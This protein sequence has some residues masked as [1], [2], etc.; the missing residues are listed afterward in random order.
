MLQKLK[1]ILY[2]FV[3]GTDWPLGD[4]GSTEVFGNLATYCIL[5]LKVVFHILWAK[6]RQIRIF[7]HCKNEEK[8]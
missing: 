5:L 8:F 1:W 7:V 6:L 3:F 2:F 4:Q